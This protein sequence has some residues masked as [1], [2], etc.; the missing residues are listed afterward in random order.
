MGSAYHVAVVHGKSIERSVVLDF[1]VHAGHQVVLETQSAEGAAE[2]CRSDPPDI[3]LVDVESQGARGLDDYTPLLQQ[4]E[5]P[6]IVISGSWDECVVT[7]A[8]S[9][10]V[11][12]CLSKPIRAQELSAAMSLAIQ[13]FQ[14][15][16]SLRDEV[17]SMRHAL[18]DRKFIERAKGILMSKRALNE[19]DAYRYLQALARS[20]RQKLVEVAKSILLAEKAMDPQSTLTLT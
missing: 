1:L 17:V 7:R 2:R 5:V 8:I 13:Q 4:R 14:E 11:F 9:C 15:L 16:K 20:H 18:E 12:A 3:V 19:A 6:V 10:G